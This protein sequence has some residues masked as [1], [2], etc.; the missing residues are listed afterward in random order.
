MAQHDQQLTRLFAFDNAARIHSELTIGIQP[1]ISV[2]PRSNIKAALHFR[3]IIGT[4]LGDNSE[5]T[6]DRSG[7]AFR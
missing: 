2:P 3:L 4:R 5:V 7:F 6:H 1:I